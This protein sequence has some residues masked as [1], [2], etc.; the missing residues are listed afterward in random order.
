[1]ETEI[2]TAIC[3]FEIDRKRERKKDKNNNNNNNGGKKD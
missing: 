1:M 2:V 3:Q